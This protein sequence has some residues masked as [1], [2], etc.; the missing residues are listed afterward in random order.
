MEHIIIGVAGFLIV[1]FNWLSRYHAWVVVPRMSEKEREQRLGEPFVPIIGG[2]LLFLASAP[3]DIPV[4]VRFLPFVIDYGGLFGVGTFVYAVA[5]GAFSKNYSEDDI[6]NLVGDSKLE[7]R[8]LHT[9]ADLFVDIRFA[10]WQKDDGSLKNCLPIIEEKRALVDHFGNELQKRLFVYSFDTLR[11][12]IE[13]NQY[14]YIADF[15]DAVHNLP[16]IFYKE[17]DLSRYW[18]L[19]IKPLRDKHGKHFFS[20]VEPLFKGMNTKWLNPRR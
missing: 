9:F 1:V 15:A 5:T 12:A 11:I 8:M 13:N 4:W 18:K 10:A 16:E 3:L 7:E 19:Y 17:Y 14:E 2:L 6:A 20:S